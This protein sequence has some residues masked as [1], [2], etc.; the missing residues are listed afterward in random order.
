MYTLRQ[1]EEAQTHDDLWTAGQIQMV[2]YGWMHNYL[3][4][5]WAKKILEWTPNVATAMNAQLRRP[6]N[7]AYLNLMRTMTPTGRDFLSVDE[8]TGAAV[9]LASDDSAAM[10]GATVMVDDGWSAW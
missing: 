8:M 10:H 9:F 1:L 2:R 5:Y 7:E 6:G 4:M 3:R